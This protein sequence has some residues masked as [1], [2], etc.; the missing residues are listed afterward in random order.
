MRHG[1]RRSRFTT[2]RDSAYCVYGWG[3]LVGLGLAGIC[4]YRGVRC[5]D[6]RNSVPPLEDIAGNREIRRA[7]RS[8][9]LE[10]GR[11]IVLA[12]METPGPGRDALPALIAGDTLA[13]ETSSAAADRYG[14]IPA[15]AFTSR[16]GAVRSLEAELVARGGAMVGISSGGSRNGPDPLPLGAA[17]G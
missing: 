15:R 12:T 10:G 16:D 14:R 13:L 5:R 8:L 2:G 3:A 6:D 1:R 11:E 17:D 4:R 9:V 7:G